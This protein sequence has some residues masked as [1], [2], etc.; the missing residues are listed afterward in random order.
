MMWE[1]VTG[2]PED[3]E[4][5]Q[6][7]EDGSERSRDYDEDDL[8]DYRA[9]ENDVFEVDEQVIFSEEELISEEDK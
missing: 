3:Y 9:Y 7:F 1:T 2:V 4:V 6:T 8:Y 5:P